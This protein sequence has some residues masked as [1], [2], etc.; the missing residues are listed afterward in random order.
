MLSF[1]SM[2]IS[3]RPDSISIVT[4][5]PPLPETQVAPARG[6]T[7]WGTL[8]HGPTPGRRLRPA[9]PRLG[10]R[11][12]HGVA[13]ARTPGGSAPGRADAASHHGRARRTGGGAGP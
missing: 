9:F 6:Y 5:A 7:G 13:A 1:P 10:R 3:L 4:R 11:G 8:A 2:T 12:G